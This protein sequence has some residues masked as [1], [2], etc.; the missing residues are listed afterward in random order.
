MEGVVGNPGQVTDPCA[1][2]G[3]AA[4]VN[5]SKDRGAEGLTCVCLCMADVVEDDQPAHPHSCGRH[6]P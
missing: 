5:V 2:M 6:V 4:S 3:T 1:G